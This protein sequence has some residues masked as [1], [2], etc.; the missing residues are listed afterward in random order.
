MPGDSALVLFS[1]GQDSTVCLAWALERYVR[2][3]TL[4]FSY[5]Q[6]HSVELTQRR[7]VR[8]SFPAMFPEWADRL[9]PDHEI[10]LAELGRISETS[11]TRETEIAMT[12]AGLPSTFVPGRNLL[13]LV[14]A[15]ALAYRRGISTLVAGMCETDYSGYPDCRA[16]TI[17]AQEEA[18]ALGLDKPFKIETPLMYV[19]KAGTWALA[20]ELGGPPLIDLIREE[21]HTCYLGDRTRRH[22]W[23]WGCG[24]C[25]ACQLRAKGWAAWSSKHR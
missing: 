24:E 2:V 5:G 15:A 8:D 12:K 9:G 7:I 11:L 19:D 10:S 4:G 18:I 20:D 25:P 3:E 22:D 16:D 1:G 23:G 13:F 21:T 6:R 14:Y 17:R